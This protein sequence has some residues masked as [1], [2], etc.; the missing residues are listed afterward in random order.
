MERRSNN[1]RQTGIHFLKRAVELDPD[2]DLSH[3]WL[4]KA[5][6]HN[7][8][9][10][11]REEI[12][13]DQE[14]AEKEILRALELNPRL[15]SAHAALGD[16]YS[17]HG[18]LE[19]ARDAYEQALAIHPYEPEAHSGIYH[20]D[21]INKKFWDMATRH[22]MLSRSQQLVALDPNR[23]EFRVQLAN[24][25][26]QLGQ[27]T[28][29]QVE[30]KKARELNPKHAGHYYAY[31]QLPEFCLGR[32][33]EAIAVYR[34]A[35]QL[36][37]MSN[38]FYPRILEV[39]HKF[40]GREEE[41]RWL[42]VT[43]SKFKRINNPRRPE[44]AFRARIERITHPESQDWIQSFE[45]VIREVPSS[46]FHRRVLLNHELRNGRAAIAIERYRSLFP[47]LFE[48][49][50]PDFKS[51]SRQTAIAAMELAEILLQLGEKERAY[52]LLDQAWVVFSELPRMG[53][54]WE[55]HERNFG[56]GIRDVVRHALKGET[57]TAL[58]GLREAISAGF[59]DRLELES[60]ALDSLRE[61]P[62]FLA[63]MNEVEADMARQLANVR[64]MQANGQLAAIPDEILE[65]MEE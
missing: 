22:A 32:L 20:L 2:F 33:D 51:G 59:R 44:I 6:L 65:L 34:D 11:T 53:W 57:Q 12:Q 9:A 14:L 17:E 24:S 61:E 50:L 16:I 41:L 3:L 7:F 48:S 28:E 63:I 38:G 23:S 19:E 18:D 37:P 13:R 55:S 27:F 5:Y 4:G 21:F 8:T 47:Q 62:E 29:A 40:G 10:M 52:D 42:K 25:L 31:A 58:A 35:I 39:Y 1:E 54:G 60:S 45:Q 26:I 36:D 56:Y 46:L 15:A 30:L 43:A 64:R 49:S